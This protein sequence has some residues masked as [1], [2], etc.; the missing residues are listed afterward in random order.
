M[1]TWGEIID[2]IKEEADTSPS[3]FDKIRRKYLRHVADVNERNVI[4]YSSG[5]NELEIDS[6]QFSITDTDVQGFMETISDLNS[7]D[8]DLILH[9]PGG[10][11][12]VAEQ[13]VTYLREKFT[14]I[15]IIVPQSAMS[16]ATLMCCAADEVVMGHHSSLGPTDPQMRIPTKTGQRWVPAQTIVDQFEEIDEKIQ[17][18]E[19]IAHYTPILSQYDPGLKQQADNAIRLSNR[20]AE[21][22]AEQ[23]M[24]A[25][26]SDASQ[27]A[28]DLSDYL[29]NHANF[30]SHNR[31]IGRTHLEENTPMKVAKL[32][33]DQELQDAVLSAFH[34]VT[35]THSHQQHT[36]IIENHQGDLYGRRI[37]E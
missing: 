31:R 28:S 37:E 19:D 29:S 36:K 5:W 11:T 13:I 25:D 9:S 15:R 30:L 33:D 32:E 34:A 4:L 20:L 1:P 16:A 23:Y 26:D 7:N 22:W 27:K 12:E 35:A 14:N 3:A 10:S 6:P 24:F 21:Q 17:A 8:L 2:E 18:G